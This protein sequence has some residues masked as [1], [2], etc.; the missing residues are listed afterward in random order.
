MYSDHG[1]KKQNKNNNMTFR[2][3]IKNF[4]I[5]LYPYYHSYC[6]A[7]NFRIIIILNYCI[8][9]MLLIYIIIL[10]FKNERLHHLINLKGKTVYV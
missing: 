7:K 10:L 3:I 9:S 6:F 2:G 1:C 4:N 5:S 8:K